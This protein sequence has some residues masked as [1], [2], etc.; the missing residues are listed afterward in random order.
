MPIMHSDVTKSTASVRSS[1]RPFRCATVAVQLP[2]P[3][4]CWANGDGRDKGEDDYEPSDQGRVPL[5][6][7]WRSLYAGP[8][9]C[10]F[11]GQTLCA[12]S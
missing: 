3:C 6:Q 7:W 9:R 8:S 5:E 12:V 1:S 2:C 4:A 11:F 10:Q